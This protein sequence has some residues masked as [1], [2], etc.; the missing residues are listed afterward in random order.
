ME[1]W[2]DLGMARLED[3][4]DKY[5]KVCPGMIEAGKEHDDALDRLSDELLNGE[6]SEEVETPVGKV[7]IDKAY[8]GH[9]VEKRK[10]ARER[11]AKYVKPTLEAPYEIWE[12][13]DGN[14]TKKQHFIAL[15]NGKYDFMVVVIYRTDGTILWNMMHG[16]RK[17]LNN[18]RKGICVYQ[19]NKGDQ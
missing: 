4:P 15:Y 2:T 1:K 3:T 9:L 16:K 8:L 6:E 18:H 17:K 5:E 11:Y 12:L 14:G 13:I 7:T 19:K 10:E